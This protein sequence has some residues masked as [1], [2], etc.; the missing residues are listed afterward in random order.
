MPR[1]SFNG[2]DDD[3]GSDIAVPSAP[4]K[5]LPFDKFTSTPDSNLRDRFWSIMDSYAENEKSGINLASLEADRFALINI[6]ISVISSP[7]SSQYGI[8]LRFIC[9]HTIRMLVDGGWTD[10]FDDFLVRCFDSGGKTFEL[11]IS[12]IRSLIENEHV[13]YI[14]SERFAVMLRDRQNNMI[15][16]TYLAK[17]ANP[18][19][20]SVLRKELLIFAKGDI[21][22]NQLN[23]LHALSVLPEDIEVKKCLIQLLSHWDTDARLSAIKFLH[24]FKND[25]EIISVCRN[26]LSVETDPAICNILSKILAR[27]KK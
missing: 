27:V 9:A 20:S 7:H 21:G 10:A 4:R 24:E 19:L 16:L 14:F 26:R 12:S 15:G 8:S 2:D 23:A 18:K 11:V 22:E 6:A 5:K 13:N 1:Q 3:S 25:D 17:I